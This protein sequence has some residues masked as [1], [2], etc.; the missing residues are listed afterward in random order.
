MDS[1]QTE[2]RIGKFEIVDKG[3]LTD[4][5]LKF[6]KISTDGSGKADIVSQRG[7]C[8]E[9][10]IFNLSERQLEKMGE[11]E[12]G[13]RPVTN[14]DVLM[15]DSVNS[16]TTFVAITEYVDNT[17]FPTEAYL[18]RIINGAKAFS[19]SPAYIEKL[20]SYRYQ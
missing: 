12:K 2:R 1:A 3:L 7:S 10:I 15:G 14:L 5:E 17:L 4:Y 18:R 19:L 8:V 20:K 6:N 16:V 11:Y 13:Y 9:G